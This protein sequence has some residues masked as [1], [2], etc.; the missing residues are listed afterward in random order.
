MTQIL[1][2]YLEITWYSLDKYN[3]D[4]GKNT[5]I[6]KFLG[7]NFRHGRIGKPHYSYSL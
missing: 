1:K 3:D 4:S 7:Y 6:L 2:I 5:T